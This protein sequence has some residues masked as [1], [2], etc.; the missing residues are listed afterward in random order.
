MIEK[1]PDPIVTYEQW[2]LNVD[3]VMVTASGLS[4][5][6]FKKVSSDLYVLLVDKCTDNQVLSFTNDGRDGFYA[7]GQLYR[8]F[9]ETAGLGG[10][11]R[12]DY[13]THPPKA[14]KES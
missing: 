11:E 8:S 12:R 2:N 7:Y 6:A 14:T 5:E 1:I 4:P 3:P 10:I 13:L 9:V